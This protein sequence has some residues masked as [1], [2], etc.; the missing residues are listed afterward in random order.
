MRQR[1]EKSRPIA[2]EE[3][4]AD[5]DAA[6]VT[7]DEC[8]HMMLYPGVSPQ[9]LSIQESSCETFELRGARRCM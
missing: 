7:V 1:Y 2:R 8:I 3:G 6:D 4:F 9:G 5:W